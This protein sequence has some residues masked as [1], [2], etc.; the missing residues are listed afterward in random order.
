MSELLK[1]V[2]ILVFPPWKRDDAANKR[3]L[4]NRFDEESVVPAES[5][6][7]LVCLPDSTF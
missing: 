6:S 2:L 1:N 4:D 5:S 7:S 3:C